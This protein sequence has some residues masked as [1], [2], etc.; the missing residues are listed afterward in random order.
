M[1][2]VKKS[3]KYSL[4]VILGGVIVYGFV[5]YFSSSKTITSDTF[6]KPEATLPEAALTNKDSNNA[7][8]LKEANFGDNSKIYGKNFSVAEG[9]ANL[10]EYV[11]PSVVNISSIKVVK[12]QGLNLPIEDMDPRMKELFKI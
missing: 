3:L 4:F 8:N 6:S 1:K 7:T 10:V 11:T 12:T 2:F 5:W 9:F